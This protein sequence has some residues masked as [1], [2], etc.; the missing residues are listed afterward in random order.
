MNPN[1]WTSNTLLQPF[2][3]PSPASIAEQSLPP[4]GATLG[5]IGGA[6]L[7]GPDLS[8]VPEAVGAM[9]GWN[10]GQGIENQIPGAPQTPLLSGQN[11]VNTAVSGLT[12]GAG[13]LGAKGINNTIQKNTLSNLKTT[14]SDI[15]NFAA[16]HGSGTGLMDY[17]NKF[18]QQGWDKMPETFKSQVFDPLN[19]Q[20]QNLL[21]NGNV[22]VDRQGIIDKYNN[23]INAI[24]N[25]NP[26]NPNNN[27]VKALENERDNNIQYLDNVHTPSNAGKKFTP[28]DYDAGIVNSRKT[29]VDNQTPDAK[30]QLDPNQSQNLNRESGNILRDSVYNAADNA[31]P[32][33]SGQLK[34]T[35]QDLRAAY[36]LRKIT[37]DTQTLKAS[38]K[39][40]PG[41]NN[42][43]LTKGTAARGLI[44]TGILSLIVNHLG[45]PPELAVPAGAALSGGIELGASK[46]G[47]P[48]TNMAGN[49]VNN[50]IGANALRLAGQATLPN[51]TK[52]IGNQIAQN[53]NNGYADN[54]SQYN[55]NHGSNS[56]TFPLVMQAPAPINGINVTD[57]YDPTT[58]Q[59]KTP[60]NIPTPSDA[61]KLQ[62]TPYQ[63][64]QAMA[65]PKNMGYGSYFQDMST[66]VNNTINSYMANKNVGPDQRDFVNNFPQTLNNLNTLESAI[67]KN[68]PGWLNSSSGLQYLN[69]Y[70]NPAFGTAMGML[71]NEKIQN[72][73]QTQGR[74]P[75][76]TE[77]Q[78]AGLFPSASDSPQTA[79][80]KLN[81]V[82]AQLQQNYAQ[83]APYVQWYNQITT[84]PAGGG[85]SPAINSNSSMPSISPTSAPFQSLSGY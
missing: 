57:N 19:E 40:Q 5:A 12:E 17:I 48:M 47:A 75:N 38:G 36:G 80:T 60:S 35:G 39:W 1:N 33:T 8:G 14:P 63:I 58:A 10:I 79:I 23:R 29:F 16:K 21:G 56:S 31:D 62:Y 83:Y 69:S 26:A 81:Q 32:A 30:F 71:N 11:A 74:A 34:Q 43:L 7:P 84:Q 55:G 20:Y 72:I 70:N 6:M 9:G 66:G 42:G 65:D 61:P 24:K 37:D 13:R 64:N 67:A 77:L 54:G 78:Q 59:W 68:P 51:I 2:N 82:Q 22:R 3:M 45:L 25:L 49:I 18:A 15:T 53:N 73:R 27:Y 41:G 52:S 46:F 50:P 76:V 44:D 4:I 85:Q 28:Q